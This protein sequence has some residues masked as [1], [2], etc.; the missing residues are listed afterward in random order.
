MIERTFFRSLGLGLL[1]GLA[2]LAAAITAP[3]ALGGVTPAQAQV[4]VS[5]E[6]R[7]ALTPHGEW[8]KHGRWGEVWVPNRRPSDWRPYENG[9]WVYTD[10]WGWFWVA[11]DTEQDWGWVTYHYGRWAHD[12]TGWFWIPGDEWAPAWVNWRYTDDY[13]GWAPLPP[14][15]VI[16]EYDDD[17]TYWVF[18]RPRY[19]TAPR[20]YDYVV[21]PQRTVVVLHDTVVI[22]RTVVVEH[23]RDRGRRFAVN[24][25]VAPGIIAAVRRNPVPTYQ[26]R[27]RVLPQTTGIPNAVQVSRQELGRRPAPN[28]RGALPTNA[29]VIQRAAS[30]APAAT[31]AKPEPLR[32]D[33][34]GRLG[35]RPPRAAQG[36]TIA[37]RPTQPARRPQAQQPQQS[38][39]LQKTQ[40]A[41]QPQNSGTPP[42]AAPGARPPSGA[43][44]PHPARQKEEARPGKPAPAAAPQHREP[45]PTRPAARP[46]PPPSAPATR[47]SAQVH[48]LPPPQA[49]P[50]P[51]PAPSQV[52]PAARPAPPQAKPRPTP[53]QARPAPRP[54]PPPQARPAPHPAPQARPTPHPAVQARPAPRPAAHPAPRPAPA[55]KPPPKKG[56][57]KEKK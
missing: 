14:D 35:S 5:V 9:H 28:R 23:D 53:A 52:R 51:R 32:K 45:P 49:K 56:E 38:P 17:P 43:A 4:Q 15:D 37:P 30:I 21:P 20:I 36:A 57:E 42:A 48:P 19:I 39:Q 47:P 8:R 12:D 54:A 22:N 24:P 55:K 29:P 44:A 46:A 50:A 6:F 33:E 41:P 16:Y 11:D 1:G 2:I 7:D 3:I 40:Q 18:V 13:V 10:E 25:G 34:R 26:V 31:V 27:P